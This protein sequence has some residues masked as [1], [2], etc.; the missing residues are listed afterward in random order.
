MISFYYKSCPN[1]KNYERNMVRECALRRR[2]KVDEKYVL[3]LPDVWGEEVERLGGVLPFL[4]DG[5]N[6]LHV[7]HEQNDMQEKVEEFFKGT[8]SAE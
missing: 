6:I 5:E 8:S 3:A 1:C 7:D 4:Y 2:I